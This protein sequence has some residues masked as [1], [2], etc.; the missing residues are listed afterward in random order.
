M[1]YRFGAAQQ[2]E[3]E[4][5]YGPFAGLSFEDA[6]LVVA[7]LG[8][9]LSLDE[10]SSFD[11]IRAQR[12]LTETTRALREAGRFSIAVYNAEATEPACTFHYQREDRS[13]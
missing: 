1:F 11:P 3:Y 9:R 13:G 8:L 2:T 12:E 7:G 4:A 10:G 6:I 5:S